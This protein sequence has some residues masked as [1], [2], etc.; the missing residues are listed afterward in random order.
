MPPDG[1]KS[2]HDSSIYKLEMYV[3]EIN[4]VLRDT[5]SVTFHHC[6]FLHSVVY[7]LLVAAARN[8]KVNTKILKT[9][10]PSSN[11]WSLA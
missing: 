2:T 1:N 3:E 9:N 8:F 6:F 4:M 11:S 7:S 10:V 5:K